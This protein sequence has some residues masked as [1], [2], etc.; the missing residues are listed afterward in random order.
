MTS[1]ATQELSELRQYIR[2]P[3][4]KFVSRSGLTLLYY[5][6]CSAN[7][8]HHWSAWQDII[9]S[10]GKSHYVRAHEWCCGHGAYGFELL[11]WNKCDTLLLS[12]I[13]EPA[14]ISCQFTAELNNFT[15]RVDIVQ[16]FDFSDLPCEEKWD[17]LVCDPP[18]GFVETSVTS[19]EVNNDGLR[20]TKDLNLELHQ[21]FFSHVMQHLLPDADVYFGCFEPNGKTSTIIKMAEKAGFTLQGKY[22]SP[23]FNY[24]TIL[25]LKIAD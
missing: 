3:I 1:S 20:Q 21:S 6:N 14:I 16:T 12:D 8:E 9:Q 10:T 19:D 7:G 18:N 24:Q 15:D 2:Y 13:F 25:H 22:S 4:K 17:L 5:T 11:Q 23:D